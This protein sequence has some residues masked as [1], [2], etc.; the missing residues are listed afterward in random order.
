MAWNIPPRVLYPTNAAS[1]GHA[2]EWVESRLDACTVDGQLAVTALRTTPPSLRALLVRGWLIRAGCTRQGLTARHADGVLRLA[3]GG[4]G[5]AQVHLPGGWTARR[6][7]G[8]LWMDRQSSPG[9][10]LPL[11]DEKAI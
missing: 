5:R 1:L 9:R 4:R 3:E 6:V 10:R 2:A 8:Y 11:T 7:G